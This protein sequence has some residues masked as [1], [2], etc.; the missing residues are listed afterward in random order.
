MYLDR[1]VT[2]CRGSVAQL[3]NVVSTPG[4][5]RAIAFEREALLSTGGDRG[6]SAQVLYLHRR[7]ALFGGPI[8]QLAMGVPTPGP[9]PAI[10]R[11][12]QTV[13]KTTG[14]RRDPA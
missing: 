6:D 9:D 1:C 3:A 10:C 14:D 13:G 7:V 5:Y 12:P 4:R 2:L 8:A 11:E